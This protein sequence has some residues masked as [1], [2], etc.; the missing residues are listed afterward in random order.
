MVLSYA[1][2][3][4]WR[5]SLSSILPKSRQQLACVKPW[6]QRRS[7]KSVYHNEQG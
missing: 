5:Y 3:N 1:F 2:R 7:T 4:I 6:L